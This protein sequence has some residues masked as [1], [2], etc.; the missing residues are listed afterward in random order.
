MLR[1]NKG[2]HEASLEEDLAEEGILATN[3][4]ILVVQSCSNPGR[5]TSPSKVIARDEIF[6]MSDYDIIDKDRRKTFFFFVQNGR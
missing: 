2:K 6:A 5:S 3:L 4:S 1:D